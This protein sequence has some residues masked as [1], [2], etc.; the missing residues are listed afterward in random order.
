MY[1]L[2]R[3]VR[4]GEKPAKS[5]VIG[6]KDEDG[7]G[8]VEDVK[9]EEPTEEMLTRQLLRMIPP[10]PAPSS[11]AQPEPQRLIG[12]S[13]HQFDEPRL[14]SYECQPGEDISMFLRRLPPATTIKDERTPWI[15]VRNPS[16]GR[17]RRPGVGSQLV[18]GCEDEGP[19]ADGSHILLFVTAARERL[20]LLRSFLDG[21]PRMGAPGTA[22]RDMDAARQS[23]AKDIIGL[24]CR[25]GV[26]CGKVGRILCLLGCQ[27][28]TPLVDVVRP[29]KESQPFVGSSCSSDTPR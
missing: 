28:L 11:I 20:D 25:L 8:D 19:E 5:V 17:P 9:D 22:A 29:A 21:I 6:V 1:K 15:Y 23:A 18:P 26:T 12:D 16:I 3:R 14:G 27:L 24:A 13:R 4:T 7:D 10:A 2:T